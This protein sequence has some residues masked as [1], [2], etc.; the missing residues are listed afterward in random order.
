M[1]VPQWASPGMLPLKLLV[2]MSSFSRLA[3][4]PRN[5]GMP[6]VLWKLLMYESLLSFAEGACGSSMPVRAV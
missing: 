5:A 4:P 6:P 2:L 1:R 3:R